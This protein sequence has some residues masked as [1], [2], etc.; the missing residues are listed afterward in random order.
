MIQGCFYIQLCPEHLLFLSR[1]KFFVF[2]LF[3]FF[4]LLYMHGVKKRQLGIQEIDEQRQQLSVFKENLDRFLSNRSNF[5]KEIYTLT[6][7]VLLFNPEIYTA[8]N[9]RRQYIQNSDNNP[10]LFTTDLSLTLQCLTKNPKLYPVW[11][12]RRWII[13]SMPEPPLEKELALCH[14]LHS[15]DGRNFHCWNYRRFISDCCKKRGLLI[16]T[17]ETEFN[18]TQVLA[19]KNFSNYSTWHHRLNLLKKLSATKSCSVPSFLDEFLF[20]RDA[21]YCDPNDESVWLYVRSLLENQST[22]MIP[23]GFDS[24]S[25]LKST[26]DFIVKAVDHRSILIEGRGDVVIDPMQVSVDCSKYDEYEEFPSFI[27]FCKQNLVLLTAITPFLT[28]TR[29]VELTIGD[30]SYSCTFP[31]SFEYDADQNLVFIVLSITADLLSLEPDS[32]WTLLS[33]AIIIENLISHSEALQSWTCPT[34]HDVYQKLNIID[35][36]RHGFYQYKLDQLSRS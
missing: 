16:G 20:V 17:D 13:S 12:H 27:T 26:D 23:Q 30:C 25:V 11:N 28:D 21:L 4:L 8:W 32:K 18:Y 22:D 29:S 1:L 36:D 33:K 7:S 10:S 9:F 31:S 15:L 35:P 24:V 19:E 5:T 34:L 3:N 14:K 6:S 2:F